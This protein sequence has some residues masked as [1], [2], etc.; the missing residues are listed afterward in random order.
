MTAAELQGAN[1]AVKAATYT[2]RSYNPRSLELYAQRYYWY[3]RALP[4]VVLTFRL[5]LT[6]I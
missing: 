3:V 4:W 5:C 1:A 2:Y 6:A